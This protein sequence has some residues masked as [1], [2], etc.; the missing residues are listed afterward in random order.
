MIDNGNGVSANDIPNPFN[1]SPTAEQ[2]QVV[3]TKTLGRIAGD[4]HSDY[5][6]A[7]EKISRKAA[8]Q[9]AQNKS[10]EKADDIKAKIIDKASEMRHLKYEVIKDADIV[11]ISVINSKD[12]TIIRK[13]PPDKVVGFVRKVREKKSERKSRLDIKA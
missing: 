3:R 2:H 13:V 1:Q 11:Q 4:F 9:E 10:D 12:G 7:F 8:Q 5:Q 6:R